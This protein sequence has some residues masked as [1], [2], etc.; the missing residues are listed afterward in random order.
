M[1]LSQIKDCQIS[2][3]GSFKLFC[4]Q[5]NGLWASFNVFEEFGLSFM[6]FHMFI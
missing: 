3:G 1:V 5:V 2:A 6:Q 4:I